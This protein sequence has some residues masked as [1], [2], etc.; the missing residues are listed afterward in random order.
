MEAVRCRDIVAQAIA[1]HGMPE[2]FNTDPGQ[3][4]YR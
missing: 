3:S 4:I 1:Q 2:I